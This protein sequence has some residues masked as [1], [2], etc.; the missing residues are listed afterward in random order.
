MESWH[1]RNLAHTPG[2]VCIENSIGTAK[3]GISI[4][5]SFTKSFSSISS[6]V[7]SPGASS[8]SGAQATLLSEFRRVTLLQGWE[9]LDFAVSPAL[10]RKPGIVPSTAKAQIVSRGFHLSERRLVQTEYDTGGQ[11]RPS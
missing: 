10:Q 7:E 9:V 4:S 2:I 5:T 8:G 11:R 1:W 6:V 3:A